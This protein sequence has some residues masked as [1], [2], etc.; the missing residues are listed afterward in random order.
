MKAAK[1]LL[2]KQ[3]KPYTVL[4]NYCGEEYNPLNEQDKNLHNKGNCEPE[5]QEKEQTINYE[6]EKLNRQIQKFESKIAEQN[7]KIKELEDK[8]EQPKGESSDEAY[9]RMLLEELEEEQGELSEDDYFKLLGVDKTHAIA[10]TIWDG[11]KANGYS[12]TRITKP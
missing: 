2:V 4:C 6:T 1:S 10:M 12:I 3:E 5:E 8:L 11:L 9:E 7:I